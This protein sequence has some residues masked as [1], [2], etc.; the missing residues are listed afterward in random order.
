MKSI[1][2][3]PTPAAFFGGYSGSL[4]QFCSSQRE[5]EENEKVSV[6]LERWDSW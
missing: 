6:V 3:S 2:D 4:S 5:E 1:P